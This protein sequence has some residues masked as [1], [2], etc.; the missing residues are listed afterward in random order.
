MALKVSGYSSTALTYKTVEQGTVTQTADVDVLGTSGTLYSLDL[1]NQHSSTV[2]IK[3][4][5]SAGEYTAGTSEPDLM[6]RIAA[7]TSRKLDIPGG[8]PFS[9][10]TFWANDG[11]NTSDTD[12]PGGT[13]VVI[14]VCS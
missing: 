11:P 13:V 7:S 2:Y 1:D 4:F 10:L 3:F 12:A 9:Q 8:L 5:L 14:A 6:F